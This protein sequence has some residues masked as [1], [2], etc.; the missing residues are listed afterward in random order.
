MDG[1]ALT[2]NVLLLLLLPVW[3]Q[4]G[5]SGKTAATFP[6][7]VPSALQ[8]FEYKQLNVTCEGFF[9]SFTKWRV[10]RNVKTKNRTTCNK[11][12]IFGA[13]HISLTYPSES[14]EYWCETETN[15][16]SE[17]VNI[18]VTSG[19]V[20]LESPVR[21]VTMGDTITLLCIGKNNSQTQADFY[22]DGRLV[23]K[24]VTG[25]MTIQSISLSDGGRY[26]CKTSKSAERSA[27]NLLRVKAVLLESPAEPVME[28]ENVTLICRDK[29]PSSN[30][31]SYFFRNGSVFG[32]SS[33]GNLTLLT[34]SKSDEGLYK[35]NIRESGESEENWLAVQDRSI[36]AVDRGEDKQNTQGMI[37][38]LLVLIPLLLVVL[39]LGLIYKK[40]KGSSSRA[41]DTDLSA[42]QSGCC[43][44]SGTE[45][46]AI[47]KKPKDKKRAAVS[48][49][50]KEAVYSVISD[51]DL[52][53]D[54]LNGCGGARGAAAETYSVVK[55]TKKNKSGGQTT[56]AEVETYSVI[57]KPRKNKSCGLTTATE[58]ILYSR[59][60]EPKKNKK[61]EESSVENSFYSQIH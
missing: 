53:E 57:N 21:A 50:T 12:S 8:L 56:K 11:D 61:A 36:T 33:T 25:N 45:T 46:Y 28:G 16:R 47:V 34:V 38:P 60:E 20:I 58:T 40:H 2:M 23:H 37:Y 54:E 51:F 30:F 10:M 5:V 55:K 6:R 24:S 18:T 9:N 1:T 22:K 17:K 41:P 59:V 52:K 14:G 35:C 13:C 49:E 26:S 42:L 29:T 43:Q 4:N 39:V 15:E 3:V 44:P 32:N 19:E 31:T 7:I 27:D 48:G